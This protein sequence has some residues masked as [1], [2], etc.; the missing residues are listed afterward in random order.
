[1]SD[2]S[3]EDTNSPLDPKELLQRVQED[4]YDEPA[5]NIPEANIPTQSFD[6]EDDLSEAV[7][8][9]TEPNPEVQIPTAPLPSVID[10]SEILEHKRTNFFETSKFKFGFALLCIEAGISRRHYSVILELLHMAQN[11]M[12]R[13]LAKLPSGVTTLK[14]WFRTQLP[15]LTMRKKRIPLAA[16]MLG[17]DKQRKGSGTAGA[18]AA[19]RSE[20]DLY[21]FDPVDLSRA[22]IS[23]D[24]ASKMHVGFGEFHDEPTELW[25]GHGWRSSI[26]TTAGNFLHYLDGKPIFPSDIVTFYCNDHSTCENIHLG[27]V[28]SVGRDYRSS[29]IERGRTTVEVQLCSLVA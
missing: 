28:Y 9:G 14:R 18:Q 7:P 20:E 2:L 1:M 6:A 25:H 27:R 29:A 3:L 17:K 24:I 4:C 23:S 8:S 5:I 16:E 22:L 26:R 13:E 15:R 10:D 12:P 21:F 11:N 19:G